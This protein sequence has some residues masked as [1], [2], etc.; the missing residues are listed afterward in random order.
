M[1]DMSESCEQ[2]QSLLEWCY[3]YSWQTALSTKRINHSEVEQVVAALYRGVKE[4][5]PVVIWCDSPWQLLTM[6]IALQLM[7]VTSDALGAGMVAR[8]YKG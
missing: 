1:F 3:A 6:P 2:M 4:P 5:P 8:Q 7:N